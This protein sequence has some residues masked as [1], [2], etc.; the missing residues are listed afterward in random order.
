[1]D[2]ADILAVQAVITRVAH[3][4]D[5]KRWSEL[6]ALFAS[7]VQTDYTSLFGGEVQDQRADALMDAWRGLLG[8]VVTQ[9]FLGP[10]EVEAAARTARSRATIPRGGSHRSAGANLVASAISRSSP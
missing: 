5:G 3:T 1:M 7:T 8:S 9:H 10:I 2:A 4:I 6:R